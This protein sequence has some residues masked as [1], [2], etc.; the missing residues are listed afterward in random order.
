MIGDTINR[1]SG[2]GRPSRR[3]SPK[4]GS[5]CQGLRLLVLQD[6]PLSI[7]SVA[8][9]MARQ[10]K[11][12][13]KN[14]LTLPASGLVVSAYNK[15]RK[16]WF[17]ALIDDAW[18]SAAPDDPAVNRAIRTNNP[19]ALNISGWQRKRRG[20]VGQTQPDGAGNITTIY[21]TPEHGVAA[22]FFLL[23]D[24]YGYAVAGYFD[25]V[26]LA[27][28]YAGSHAT[29]AEVR[30]Y[31][32]GWS[33][34]SNGALRRDTIIHLASDDEMLL[35]A[36]AEFAHEAAAPS[37]LRDRQVVCGFALERNTAV[38]VTS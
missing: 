2:A 13:G 32:D 12:H 5:D 26:S 18:F 21:Q 11:S 23:S 28:K 4:G 14:R 31:T 1:N 36:K 20:Y 37:P 29:D 30:A 15:K 38:P 34:W 24:R 9:Q 33:K 27:K 10:V 17:G 8:I 35:F 25:L 22:W 3:K 6:G 16:V 19:G 7:I